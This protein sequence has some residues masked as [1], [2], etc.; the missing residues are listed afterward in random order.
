MLFS[1]VVIGRNYFGIGFFYSNLKT[2]LIMMMIII[3]I[4]IL[5]FLFQR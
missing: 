3:I 5:L 1:L 4:I 2:T